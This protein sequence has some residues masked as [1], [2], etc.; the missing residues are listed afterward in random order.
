M[1]R[2]PKRRTVEF[3]PPCDCFKPAGVPLAELDEVHLSIDELEA[4]RLKD[5]E[6][7]DH[8]TSARRMQVSRPTFHRILRSA[9]EKVAAALTEG[10]ALRIEGG[11]YRLIGRH[12]CR[13][14]G[15]VWRDSPDEND[16]V[17]PQCGCQDVVRS[18]RGH[19]RRH[20]NRGRG[21][22]RTGRR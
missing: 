2:P 6:S 7:L 22:G 17:C 16:P 13:A 19:G 3:L 9:H 12:L 5:Q 20:R 21:Q 4:I 10:R 14:C 11:S 1:P 8:E 18:A 15:R